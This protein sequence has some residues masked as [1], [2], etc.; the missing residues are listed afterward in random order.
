M[1]SYVVRIYRR[2]GGDAVAGVMEDSLSQQT[3]V[4]H[5]LAELAQWLRNPPHRTQERS[6]PEA[7]PP[8]G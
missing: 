6:S 7:S 5:S 1:E 2:E 4:F 3:V 8:E